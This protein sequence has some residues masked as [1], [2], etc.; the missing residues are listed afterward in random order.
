VLLTLFSPLTVARKL[1]GD[2]LAQD[3]RQAPARV[4]PALEAI[5]ATVLR[6][7]RTAFEAGADGLFV[8]TQT[9]TPETFSEAE[10]AEWDLGFLR[11]ILEGVRPLSGLTM[12]HIHGRDPYFAVLAGLPAH[13]VNWHDRRT[14]PTLGQ[15]R[16]RF[17]GALAGGLDEW[18]TLRQ[19]PTTAIAGEVRDAIGQTAGLGLI[20][21]PGCVLP[22]DVPDAHLA[23]VVEAVRGPARR[24]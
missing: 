15:A 24:H 19:G 22:L 18:G 9:A 6:Y 1:A 12:L 13:A 2:R 20:V 14:K 10:H 7:A 16:E 11:R 23:A 21:A 3:L 4:R 8:A 17:A 5:T